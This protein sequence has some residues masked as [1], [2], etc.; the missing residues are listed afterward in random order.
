MKTNSWW[1][2]A[3]PISRHLGDFTSVFHELEKRDLGDKYA[4]VGGL[5][6]AYWSEKF[7]G[8]PLLSHDIDYRGGYEVYDGLCWG[9]KTAFETHSFPNGGVMRRFEFSGDDGELT[10]EVL[11]ALAGLDDTFLLNPRKAV[12]QGVILRMEPLDSMKKK[13]PTC[14]KEI[15]VLDPMSLFVAKMPVWNHD[16]RRNAGAHDISHMETL[17]QIIPAFLDFAMPE[18][19]AGRIERHPA[20]AANR[21]LQEMDAHPEQL[22]P[23]VVPFVGKLRAAC[24]SCVESSGI[25][26]SAFAP[27]AL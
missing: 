23:Q 17:A 25:S 3:P 16:Y 26:E 10:V 15:S 7:L 6:T 22:P 19:A 21:L 11:S 27:P 24:V 9:L 1:G 5:G 8:I 13:Y 4:L 12:P 18:Y 20:I 2:S 14:P